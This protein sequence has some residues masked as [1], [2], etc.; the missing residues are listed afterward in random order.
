MGEADRDDMAGG[1][2]LADETVHV[3]R[4]MGR[5][6]P[7]VIDDEDVHRGGGQ[8]CSYSGVGCNEG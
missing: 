7:I 6:G 4:G 8:Q 1:L 3:G 2:Q 5:R